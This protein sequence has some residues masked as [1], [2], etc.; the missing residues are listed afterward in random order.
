MNRS[1]GALLTVQQRASTACAIEPEALPGPRPKYRTG[2]EIVYT[3]LRIHEQAACAPSWT[4]YL[5]KRLLGQATVW[6]SP[7]LTPRGGLLSVA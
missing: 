5:R 1:A 4:V 3:Q 7:Y 6:R 2:G